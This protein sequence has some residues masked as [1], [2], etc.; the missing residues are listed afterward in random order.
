M[1]SMTAGTAEWRTFEVVVCK[2]IVAGW[3]L[4]VLDEVCLTHLGFVFR[5]PQGNYQYHC[6]IFLAN[7]E[8]FVLIWSTYL[9]HKNL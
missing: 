5:F 2:E 4:R 8:Y 6:V 7:F 9:W 1:Y 3:L